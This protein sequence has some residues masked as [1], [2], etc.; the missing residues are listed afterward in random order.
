MCPMYP[1][2]A[3]CPKVLGATLT[4]WDTLQT[5]SPLCLFPPLPVNRSLPNDMTFIHLD[6][7]SPWAGFEILDCFQL[8]PPL[9]DMTECQGSSLILFLT[10]STFSVSLSHM[11]VLSVGADVCSCPHVACVCVLGGGACMV[12]TL[13][14]AILSVESTSCSVRGGLVVCVCQ[15]EVFMDMWGCSGTGGKWSGGHPPENHPCMDL[16]ETREHVPSCGWHDVLLLGSVQK[17][18]ACSAQLE[19]A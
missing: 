2:A 11:H 1:T 16:H 18:S 4:R 14:K 15:K 13:V 7:V 12:Q 19:A 6:V 10:P 8:V 5:C 3:T 9:W 17:S